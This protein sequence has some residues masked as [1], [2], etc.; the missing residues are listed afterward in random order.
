VNAGRGTPDVSYNAD[1]YTGV[2]VYFTDPTLNG[3][4]GWYVFG[5]TSAGTPQWAALLA[6]RASLGNAG[7]NVSFSSLLYGAANSSYTSLLRD[8][9]T[10]GNGYP[11]VK[12]YDLATGLG[13]PVGVGIATLAALQPAPSPTPVPTPSPTP[14]PSPT[15]TPTPAPTATP[16]PVPS[17]TATPR[18]SPSPTA[19]PRPS[20]TPKP[21]PPGRNWWNNNWW[22]NNWFR[23]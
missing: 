5:G 17:P 18:P 13:S 20:P 11:A 19:T 21:T 9:T 15:A 7:S 23:W 3:A 1:P 6:R 22:N 10:G 14:L 12:S 8:I 2:S 16:T 4:G